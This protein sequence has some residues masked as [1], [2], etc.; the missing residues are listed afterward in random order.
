MTISKIKPRLRTRLSYEII[1]RLNRSKVQVPSQLFTARTEGGAL[2]AEASRGSWGVS[3]HILGFRKPTSLLLPGGGDAGLKKT[4][5]F[6]SHEDGPFHRRPEGGRVWGERQRR[7]P[8]SPSFIL[9]ARVVLFP[10]SRVKGS[11]I[12]AKHARVLVEGSAQESPTA[13]LTTRIFFFL[14]TTTWLETISCL[15]YSKIREN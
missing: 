9:T 1:V 12:S 10:I 5:V 14:L 2:C 8:A 15:S 3:G 7:R 4:T 11:C 13:I 6:S